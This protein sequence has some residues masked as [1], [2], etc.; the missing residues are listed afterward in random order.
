MRRNRA[1]LLV[2]A[3]V[4]GA[5]S[6]DIPSEPSGLKRAGVGAASLEDD[7]IQKLGDQ[8]NAALELQGANYRVA[9]AEWLGANELGRVVFFSDR[10]N[11][12]LPV[13]FVPNDP[14]RGG[15]SAISYIIDQTEGSVDGLTV[16]QTSAA[17]DRAMAT[18][19]SQKCSQGLTIPRVPDQ[20]NDIGVVE[21][22]NGLGGS[23][24]VY[25]DLQHT[26]WLP[27]GILP[28]RV[29]AVTFTFIFVDANGPT[30]IDNN[31]SID[32]AFREVLYND[33]PTIV[34]R[35]DADVDVETVALHES[36][37]GLSQEH[38]GAA[39][40]T[41]ENGKLHF[42]PRAVMNAGYSGVQ[43]ALTGSDAGGHC[44]NWGSWPLN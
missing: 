24:I 12:Q 1:P 36:G 35:I 43:Q 28:P 5:C 37:H 31:G 3:L 27:P 11:K 40:A 26:G 22:L 25:A 13:D 7:A 2:L 33:H 18:W 15:G 4:V 41:I 39:F 21:F 16:A 20:P 10:G 29:L 9:Q 38:F 32:A 34:W 8:V 14:R 6:S 19:D 42:S 44:S 23:P 17:I 30:D